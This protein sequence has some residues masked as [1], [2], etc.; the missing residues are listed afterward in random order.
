MPQKHRDVFK[1]ALNLPPVERAELIEKLFQ[2]FD[3]S[4]N[5]RINGLWSKESEDRID[6]YENGK[7]KTIASENVFKRINRTK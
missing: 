7:M 1:T 3:F 5:K 6:A 2:S 4:E